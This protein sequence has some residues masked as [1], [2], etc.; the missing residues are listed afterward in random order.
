MVLCLNEITQYTPRSLKKGVEFLIGTKV[1]T[2]LRA[3][4]VI[5]RPFNGFNSHKL[6]AP[7]YLTKRDSKQTLRLGF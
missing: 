6:F 7:Q 3:R 1:H 4:Q 5:D 2:S